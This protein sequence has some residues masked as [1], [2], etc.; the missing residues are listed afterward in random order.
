MVTSLKCAR[1]VCLSA[2]TPSVRL[3]DLRVLVPGNVCVCNTNRHLFVG[4]VEI[5]G[6][7]DL[8]P[9]PRRLFSG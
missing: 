2:V 3:M 8:P 7:Y 6:A 5:T 4:L 9:E 1:C